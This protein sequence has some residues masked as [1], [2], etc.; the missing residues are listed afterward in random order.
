MTDAPVFYL[1]IGD[2]GHCGGTLNFQRQYWIMLAFAEI[3]SARILA[4]K[5]D[6][7]IIA[8][9]GGLA[10]ELGFRSA[11]IISYS[12]GL[13]SALLVLDSNAARAGWWD[14]Y[15]SSGLRTSTKPVKD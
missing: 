11:Y 5:E 14:E 1:D 10:A 15:I 13:K 3:Y 7:D 9:L 6:N 4:A 12:S 2:L 8:I